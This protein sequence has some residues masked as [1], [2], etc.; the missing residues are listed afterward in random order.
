MSS[1]NSSYSY[2]G[3]PAAGMLTSAMDAYGGGYASGAGG[4]GMLG[5]QFGNVMSSLSGNITQSAQRGIIPG[6]V[7]ANQ[8]TPQQI[9][10]QMQYGGPLS[11]LPFLGNSFIPKLVFP[12]AGAWTLYDGV[13]SMN[14]MRNELKYEEATNKRFDPT[15]LSYEQTMADIDAG[16]D[17][18]RYGFRKPHAE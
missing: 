10:A 12:L 11:V 6:A 5:Q 18:E 14:N 9:A 16:G 3:N 8:M 1:Y 2:A 17:L 15:K 7:N 13:K 4:G